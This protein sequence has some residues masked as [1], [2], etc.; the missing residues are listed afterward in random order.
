MNKAKKV[1]L[2]FFVVSVLVVGSLYAYTLNVEAE[3]WEKIR[4]Y[5]GITC[6][7]CKEVEAFMEERNASSFLK[8]EMK[9]IYENIENAKEMRMRAQKCELQT[10][11]V[12]VPFIY[13]EGKCYV[14][15]IEAE[16]L[17][18]KELEKVK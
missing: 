1:I 2:W 18:T 5:Y 11:Q 7:H 17:I 10:N 4:F 15:K 14:G 16:N 8:I 9:E 3:N 6:T 12:G 13:F